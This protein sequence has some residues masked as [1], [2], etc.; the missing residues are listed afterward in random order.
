MSRGFS[1][2]AVVCSAFS[3]TLYATRALTKPRARKVL[4]GQRSAL[5]ESTRHLG[6]DSDVRETANMVIGFCNYAG[7]SKDEADV[8]AVHAAR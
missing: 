6:V 5:V 8:S 7:D 1:H 4:A 3:R 2:E